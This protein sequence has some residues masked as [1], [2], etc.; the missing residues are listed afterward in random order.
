M[1]R[2]EFCASPTLRIRC[3]VSEITCTAEL[4]W[5]KTTRSG[6]SKRQSRLD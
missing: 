4:A 1:K 3:Q 6:N 5:C 2:W